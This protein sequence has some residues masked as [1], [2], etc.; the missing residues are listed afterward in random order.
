MMRLR[1]YAH[2]FGVLFGLM[3]LALII[4]KIAVCETDTAWKRTPGVQCVLGPAVAGV[5]L[6]SES[7]F[8][9]ILV[10]SR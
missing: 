3:W 9:D 1:T 4:L 5:E 2:V 7:R 10:T 8:Y 6:A